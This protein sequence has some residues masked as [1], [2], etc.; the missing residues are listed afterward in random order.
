MAGLIFSKLSNRIKWRGNARL[1]SGG[2]M[3]CYNI[4]FWNSAAAVFAR[5]WPIIGTN[6]MYEYHLY[7][8][9]RWKIAETHIKYVLKNVSERSSRVGCWGRA[10][11]APELDMEYRSWLL[12]RAQKLWCTDFNGICLVLSQVSS[13]PKP[14]RHYMVWPDSCIQWIPHITLSCKSCRKWRN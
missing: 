4:I 14:Q 8:D 3:I 12:W 6:F 10:N 7:A 5:R 9:L 1:L 2:R 13:P 11:K